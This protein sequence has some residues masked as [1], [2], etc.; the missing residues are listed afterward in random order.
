MFNLI[1]SIYYDLKGFKNIKLY[2]NMIK[3]KIRKVSYEDKMVIIRYSIFSY[4]DINERRIENYLSSLNDDKVKE[5]IIDDIKFFSKESHEERIRD[6]KIK[7]FTKNVR[8]IKIS[9]NDMV[10]REI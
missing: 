7:S 10:A 3:Y 5:I 1:K 6:K 8:N 2:D 9:D 4:G